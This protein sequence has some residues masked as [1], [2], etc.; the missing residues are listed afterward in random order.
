MRSVKY[1]LALASLGAL[2][3]FA[4]CTLITDVDRSQIPAS[5]ASTGEAGEGNKNGPR[6]VRL[7]ENTH[8]SDSDLQNLKSEI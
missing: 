5:D 2:V 4:S 1:T 6:N 7:V 8:D 3:A